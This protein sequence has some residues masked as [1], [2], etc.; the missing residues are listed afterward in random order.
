VALIE[1]DIYGDICFCG[2]RPRPIHAFD[3]S[4]NTMLCTSF[5]KTVSPSLRMGFIVCPPAL[6]GPLCAARAI[7]GRHG[8]TL[9][10]RVLA[11]F[12]D[13]GHLARH[14]RR[15]RALYHERQTVL[16][17]ACRRHLGG[18]LQLERADSGLQT[19]GWLPSGVD[20]RVVA[21]SARGLGVE[22]A[23]LSRFC[24]QATRPPAIVLGFGAFA[25]ERIRAAVRR[26]AQIDFG[27]AAP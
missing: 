18:R 13:E 5:S 15:M 19:I 10:Q 25:P 20:D 17:D 11:R 22:A 26:L 12:I 27:S 9:E 1:D 6:V 14:V 21:V 8:S 7:S 4:G 2:E 16:L 23:P 3:A 24:I